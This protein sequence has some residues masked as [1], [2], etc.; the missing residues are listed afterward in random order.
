MSHANGGPASSALP[1]PMAYRPWALAELTRYRSFVDTGRLVVIR[2]KLP[3]AQGHR[4]RLGPTRQ[5]PAKDGGTEAAGNLMRPN[6]PIEKEPAKF[7]RDPLCAGS[8][9]AVMT[10]HVELTLEVVSVVL[11]TAPRHWCGG[12]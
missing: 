9:V 7:K 12:I 3:R 2:R 5:F 10:H 8:F 1:W 11:G 4:V 6:G